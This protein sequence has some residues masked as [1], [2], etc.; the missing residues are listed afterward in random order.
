MKKIVL[1]GAM[2]L[3]MTANMTYNAAHVVL[4]MTVNGTI[5]VAVDDRWTAHA[6]STYLRQLIAQ[7]LG[8]AP[9]FVTILIQDGFPLDNFDEIQL[10][11]IHIGDYLIARIEKG[12][13]GVRY[14]IKR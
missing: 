12:K 3:A 6:T 14:V 4:V 10:Y 5:E 13:P 8:V 1:F 9:E 11:N 7:E 2:I